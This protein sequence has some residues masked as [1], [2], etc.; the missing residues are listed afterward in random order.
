[1]I[2]EAASILV[3]I[4]APRDSVSHFLKVAYE[5]SQNQLGK[6]LS[7]IENLNLDTQLTQGPTNLPSLGRHH[8]LEEESSEYFSEDSADPSGSDFSSSSQDALSLQNQIQ[9]S[10]FQAAGP[11]FV[12][13]F[14]PLPLNAPQYPDQRSQMNLHP[15]LVPQGATANLSAAHILSA[16]NRMPA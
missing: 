11:P 3:Q 1:M 14:Q 10:A 6:M 2:R 13:H 5:K 15:Q 9:A 16:A 7:A 8:H 12:S 4:A